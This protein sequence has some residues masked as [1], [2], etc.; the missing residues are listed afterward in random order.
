M[1]RV[2][3]FVVFA[4]VS[5]TVMSQSD[6]LNPNNRVS[7]QM[8][9]AFGNGYGYL[10]KD[11]FSHFDLKSEMLYSAE[12]DNNKNLVWDTLIQFN[13]YVGKDYNSNASSN[14][15]NQIKLGGHKVN[16][17]ANFLNEKNVNL[18]FY[19]QTNWS[20]ISWEDSIG[21][22]GRQ[23]RHKRIM[24]HLSYE[25]L[26]KIGIKRFIFSTGVGVLMGYAYE[27][28]LSFIAGEIGEYQ[29]I[30]LNRSSFL[31]SV[32]IPFGIDFLANKKLFFFVNKNV[33][34]VSSLYTPGGKNNYVDVHAKGLLIG[35]KYQL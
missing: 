11:P 31:S 6:S 34:G 3:V 25:Q 20:S 12:W 4:F 22:N 19:R 5:F 35:L 28:R 21:M 32:Y 26:Y 9:F 23:F 10:I 16:R 13:N 18:V 7:K 30:E 27:N 8:S 33:I 17:G 24:A 14:F 1:K 2:L 29:R 15:L